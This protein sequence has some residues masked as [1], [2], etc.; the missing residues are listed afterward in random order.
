MKYEGIKATNKGA[1]RQFKRAEEKG[2]NGAKHV[3][4]NVLRITRI[5]G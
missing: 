3:F 1:D 5:G 4:Q 2:Q